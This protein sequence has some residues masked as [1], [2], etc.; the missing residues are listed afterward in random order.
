[1]TYHFVRPGRVSSEDLCFKKAVLTSGQCKLL[2][3]MKQ[4]LVHQSDGI[5]NV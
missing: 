1:M 3:I 2:G 5:E 4:N